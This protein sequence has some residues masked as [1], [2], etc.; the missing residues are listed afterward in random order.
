MKAVTKLLTGAAAVAAMTVAAAPASAQYYPSPYGGGNVLGQVLQQVLNPYGGQQYGYGNNSQALVQ[1]CTAAVQQQLGQ[2][3][4][5]SYGNGY[6]Y[7]QY[8]YNGYNNAYGNARI[9][10][11]TRVE[12]RSN[13]TTR[14]RG[15]ASSGMNMGYGYNQGYGYNPY[16]GAQAQ[17]DLSFKCDIDYRGYVRDI[18]INRR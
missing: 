7:N 9:V 13:T 12:R 14:V 10:G 17:A 8:G 5:A 1:R 11:I 4:N 18:D 2:R 3:Y 6:G 15:L 16:Q